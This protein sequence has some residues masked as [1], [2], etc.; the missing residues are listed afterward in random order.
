MNQ[1]KNIAFLSVLAA[2][3]ILNVAQAAGHMHSS[4]AHAMHKTDMSMKDMKDMKGME[5]MKNARNMHTTRER[6][7]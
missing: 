7:K 2:A 5:D 3:S 1:L 6:N 4:D